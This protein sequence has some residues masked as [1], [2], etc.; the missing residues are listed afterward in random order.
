MHFENSIIYKICLNHNCYFIVSKIAGPC[1]MR[2]SG[3][4]LTGVVEAISA[5]SVAHRLLICAALSQESSFIRCQHESEDIL[6]TVECLRGLGAGITKEFCGY[7]VEPL[8]ASVSNCPI[9]PCRESGST[10]RFLLPVVG[11]LGGGGQFKL[12]GRLPQRPLAP[13]DTELEKHGLG[14][15]PRGLATLTVSGQ[16]KPGSYS[17]PGNIS[18]QYFSGLL[19]ALPLLD[20]DSKIIVEGP[21]E[22]KQYL[23]LTLDALT[24]FGLTI[25]QTLGDNTIFDIPGGQLYK[26][27]SQGE[28]Q[29]EGDWSNAAFWLCAGALSEKGIECTHLNLNSRQGDR[30]VVDILEDF[31]AVVA[32]RCDSVWVKKGTLR[33]VTID[34]EQIPD[35]VPILAVVAAVAQGTTNIIRAGRLRLKESDRLAVVC[36]TL[37]ILGADITEHEDSLTITGVASLTGGHVSSHGDHRIAM[38]AAIASTL[39]SG[40]VI[41]DEGRAVDKSYPAFYDDFSALGGKAQSVSG[42]E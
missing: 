31:G 35:L 28:T 15:S 17:L 23:D 37:K 5:K 13:L 20:G 22:S 39:S 18:S 33:G 26:A 7:K 34:A 32:R 9:L 11:A 10:L 27:P 21:L 38:M 25:R 12:Q 30:A 24:Q 6:A 29:V 3:R 42:A 14:L 8:R 16:L 40:D 1:N 19:L 36:Q 2:V 41:I 4:N